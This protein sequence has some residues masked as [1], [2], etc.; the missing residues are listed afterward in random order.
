[1]A[2]RVR[3][4]NESLRGKGLGQLAEFLEA[5]SV[6]RLSGTDLEEGH[7][8]IATAS[9]KRLNYGEAH[10]MKELLRFLLSEQALRAFAKKK[11]MVAWVGQSV[12][13]GTSADRVE[14]RRQGFPQELLP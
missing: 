2:S 5:P 7:D 13:R 1:M 14:E 10:Q 11:K 12:K 9:F 8:A 3:L 4:E 6:F